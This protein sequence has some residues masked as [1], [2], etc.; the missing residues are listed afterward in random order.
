MSREVRAV[1]G[2]ERISLAKIREMR[3]GEGGLSFWDGLGILAVCGLAA[4]GLVYL[5]V[6]LPAGILFALLKGVLGFGAALLGFIG[7]GNFYEAL[8]RRPQHPLLDGEIVARCRELGEVPEALSGP[9]DR[10]LN[11]FAGI[12][13]VGTD[14][15]WARSGISI[16]DYLQPARAQML[17]L[18][19]RG[20]QLGRVAAMLQRFEEQA[21]LPEPY[22]EVAALYARHCEQFAAAAGLMEQ[23]EASLSRALL[24]GPAAGGAA[25]EPLGELN[26]R[27]AALAET[28]E[29]ISDLPAPEPVVTAPAAEV[30]TQVPI[31]RSG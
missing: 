7:L 4:F 1:A 19:E 23:A 6:L 24:A 5:A 11:A 30:A 2:R 14:P 21:S 17:A 13:Q 31:R 27:F 8:V 16:G 12:Q 22:R 26:S 9:A 18:L 10:A 20:H 25:A 15:A 29:T 3:P 28:L